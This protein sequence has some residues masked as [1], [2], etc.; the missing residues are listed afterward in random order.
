MSKRRILFPLVGLLSLF[1][2]SPSLVS[3]QTGSLSDLEAEAALAGKKEEAPAADTA[4]DPDPKLAKQVKLE[5]KATEARLNR[6]QT[7]AQDFADIEESVNRASNLM[8]GAMNAFFMK[9]GSSL[10]DYQAAAAAG[11]EKK[12]K[13]L[14]KAVIKIRKTFLKKLK[15]TN[16]I[17]DK[18]KKL[19]AKLAKQAAEEAA[20]DSKNKAAEGNAADAKGEE[21]AGDSE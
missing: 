20:E 21:A 2:F 15:K 12:M 6:L 9:H 8:L 19:E 1:L 13:K 7:A 5:R 10:N 14:G 18:L 3:A 16:R 11:D 4:K 17:L